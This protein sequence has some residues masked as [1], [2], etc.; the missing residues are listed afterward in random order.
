MAGVTV[1]FVTQ[2]LDAGPIVMQAGV[3]VLDDDTAESLTERILK[4]EHE[5]YP[6]AIQRV[7]A[8]GWT[9]DGRRVLFRPV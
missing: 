3:P 5:L 9:V 7:L 4:V 8:G 2:E 1:H 6:E